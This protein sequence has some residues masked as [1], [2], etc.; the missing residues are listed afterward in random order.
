MA[1][2]N[3][4]KKGVYVTMTTDNTEKKATDKVLIYDPQANWYWRERGNGQTLHIEEAGRYVRSFAEHEVR[5]RPWLK[6]VEL[7][8]PVPKDGEEKIHLKMSDHTNGVD[9]SAP[10]EMSAE[11]RAMTFLVP[12]LQKFVA[13]NPADYLLDQNLAEAKETKVV[14]AIMREF[15][16]EEIRK[17]SIHL[18]NKGGISHLCIPDEADSYIKNN[19]KG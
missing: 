13:E 19:L 3:N 1:P 4:P 15:A 7:P 14:A 2:E 9:Y 5:G 6:I 12:R 17:F 8:A 10:A 18:K 16:A 11:D